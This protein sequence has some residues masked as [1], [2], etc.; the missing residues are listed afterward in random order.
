M[1]AARALNTTA[2]MLPVFS[3]AAES[4]KRA[5]TSLGRMNSTWKGEVRSER[6]CVLRFVRDAAFRERT[7][8]R[9]MKELPFAMPADTAACCMRVAHEVRERA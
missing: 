6:E 9:R 5:A 8:E 4:A 3:S 7:S 2:V 1:R